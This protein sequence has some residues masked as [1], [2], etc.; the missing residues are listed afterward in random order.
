VFDGVLFTRYWG[1]SVRDVAQ[2]V[3]WWQGDKDNIVPIGHARH[4]VDL[5]PNA[6]LRI[7]EGGGHLSGLGL[8][9]EVL[10]T[11]LSWD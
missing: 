8:G 9:A 1:F 2:P 7:L 3:T 5:L 6:E 4:I 10:E 11:V